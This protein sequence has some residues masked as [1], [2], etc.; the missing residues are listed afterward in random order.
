MVL[1][2]ESFYERYP[3]LAVMLKF[4]QLERIDDVTEV[5]G[6]HGVSLYELAENRSVIYELSQ[7]SLDVKCLELRLWQ[8]DT[9]EN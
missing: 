7:Y 6:N 9:K 1:A 2:A 4:F 8:S 3:E 5:A